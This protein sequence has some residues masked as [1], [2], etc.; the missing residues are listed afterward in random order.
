MF[1]MVAEEAEPMSDT[2]DALVDE[3]EAAADRLETALVRIAA[4][5][6]KPS[7]YVAS[8]PAISPDTAL[9]AGKLDGLIDRVRDELAA[10]AGKAD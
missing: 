10:T 3:A 6:S 7:T 5:L 9:L 4:G 1:R 2:N 8:A